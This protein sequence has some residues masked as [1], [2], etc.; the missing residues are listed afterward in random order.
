M[1]TR[2]FFKDDQNFQKY[3]KITSVCFSELHEKPYYYLLI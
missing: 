3:E 1:H 2:V